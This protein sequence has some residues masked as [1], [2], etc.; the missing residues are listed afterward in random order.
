MRV[1]QSQT[2][3]SGDMR[4]SLRYDLA[5]FIVYFVLIAY[6]L[7]EPTTVEVFRHVF[8]I[9]GG[10]RSTRRQLWHCTGQWQCGLC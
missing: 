3:I 9:P 5:F 1:V 6:L 4:C 2:V 7:P 8:Q 10:F